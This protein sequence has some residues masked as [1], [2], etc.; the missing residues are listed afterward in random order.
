MATQSAEGDWVRG[1][2]TSE[3]AARREAE[4]CPGVVVIS[5]EVSGWKE[6]PV[7]ELSVGY[8]GGMVALVAQIIDEENAVVRTGLLRGADIAVTH[9]NESSRRIAHRTSC[10]SLEEQFDR[11][12]AWNS[13]LRERLR[14]NVVAGKWPRQATFTPRG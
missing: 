10:A 9:M 3:S 6:S 1:E 7:Y 11:T 5:R 8:D 4:Q 13:R 12:R 2:V 14:P